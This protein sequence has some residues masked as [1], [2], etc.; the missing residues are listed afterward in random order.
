MSSDNCMSGDLM[1]SVIHGLLGSSAYGVMAGRMTEVLGQEGEHGF[2]YGRSD[3][4]RRVVV[5]IN[6][7][8]LRQQKNTR[9]E[10]RGLQEASQAPGRVT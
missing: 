5:E 3:W 7:S 10:A 9:P 6:R 8:H 2:L 4:G 1:A